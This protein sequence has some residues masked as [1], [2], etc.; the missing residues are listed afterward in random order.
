MIRGSR[1]RNL[2]CESTVR[3]SNYRLPKRDLSSVAPIK[4]EQAASHGPTGNEQ[5]AEQSF[6][7]TWTRFWKRHGTQRFLP[8]CEAPP[9]NHLIQHG[10]GPTYARLFL[11]DNGLG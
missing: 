7:Q 5:S 2:T 11:K 10:L 9:L 8:S 4:G 1:N 3:T 6:H